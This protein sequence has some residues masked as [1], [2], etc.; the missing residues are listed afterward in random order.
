MMNITFEQFIKTYNFRYV[1]SLKGEKDL[2]NDTCI[3]RIYPPT[4]EFNQYR[5]NWFEFGVYDFSQ[6]EVT[7]DLCKRVLSKEILESYID[8]IQYNDDYNAVVTVYLTKNKKMED[9]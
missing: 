4:E 7:W 8:T 9:Y 2:D 5:N 3:I 1:N 6:K